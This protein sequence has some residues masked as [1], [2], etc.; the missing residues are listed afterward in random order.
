MTQTFTRRTPVPVSAQ[1]LYDWHARPAAFARLQPPWERVAIE[2][3]DGPFADGQRVHI[4]AKLFGPV[5]KLWVAELFDVV[6]GRRFRDRQ[7]TGPF[8][9]W[10]HTHTFEAAGPDSSVLED[11]VEY[12]VPLGAVGRAGDAA[13]DLIGPRLDAMFAYRHALTVS[14]LTRHAR[15][16]DRPRLTVAV[17]GSRGLIGSELCHFLSTGGHRVVRL[18][19]GEPAKPAFDDGTESRRWEPAAEVDPD[20]LAGVDAVVH[21]AGENLAA[22][23]WTPARKE[24]IRDSRVGPT[25]RLAE[26]VA[27]AGVKTF[28]SASAVGIYGCRGDEVQTEASPV[29]DTFLAGVC[30][31]W[32]AAAEPAHAAPGVRVVHP[33]IG[34]VLSPKGGAL[35]EQLPAFKA[36]GGAVL[37]GGRQWVSWVGM[38]DLLGALHHCL[39]TGSLAGPVN[40]VAPEPV[41][42]RE[43]GRV[44]ARVLRRP[45]LLTV[46]G[47]ALRLLFGELADAAL[48][49]ST[50]AAPARLE[51][52]GFAF[53]HPTLEAALRSVLGRTRPPQPEPDALARASGPGADPRPR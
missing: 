4:R 38:N 39:M 31:E 23:R 27:R 34:V 7:L 8:A 1:A 22:G 24:A 49:C 26:A 30:E 41:T 35:A 12:E 29:N 9:R 32:E 14:D 42:N 48:L 53:D 52:S 45:Y 10:E 19:R 50:R 18:V 3:V 25:R 13:L 36:G 6:P 33:R 20:T 51:A 44:L 15:F 5:S 43:F 17:T 46:P 21:L 37:G 47:P 2:R 16:R 28:V 40:C 11:R